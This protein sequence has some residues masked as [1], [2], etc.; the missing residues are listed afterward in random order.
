MAGTIFVVIGAGASK[1]SISEELKSA[2]ARWGTEQFKPLYEPPLVTDLFDYRFAAIL[3][4][5]PLLQTA[6]PVIRTAT[7]SNIALEEYLRTA[8]R[9]SDDDVNRRVYAAIPSYLQ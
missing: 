6:V 9:D 4:Q 8:Y 1:A 3:N 2:S 5:Y 7:Q